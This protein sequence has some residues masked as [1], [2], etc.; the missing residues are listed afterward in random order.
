M[1]VIYGSF[2]ENPFLRCYLCW[3][4]ACKHFPSVWSV[5]LVFPGQPCLSISCLFNLQPPT[6]ED[7][8]C[9][10][11]SDGKMIIEQKLMAMGGGYFLDYFFIRI[12]SDTMLYVILY[13][14]RVNI[15]LFLVE[16]HNSRNILM[17][18]LY[19]IL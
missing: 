4:K 2:K 9:N 19:K 1:F 3:C 8:W 18:C 5:W 6:R 11:W 10:N 15:R 14:K 17:Y 7:V 12:I 16:I 13:V